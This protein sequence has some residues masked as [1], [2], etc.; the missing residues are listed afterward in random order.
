[1][2]VAEGL[3]DGRDYV[4][5]RRLPKVRLSSLL[6]AT[7]VMVAAA[8]VYVWS[9]INMTKL[10]Y[11]IAE[12]LGVREMLLQEGKKLKLEIATLKS[13]QRIAR[14]ARERLN[15]GPPTQDQVVLIK[16]ETEAPQ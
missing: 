14:I 6:V 1:M 10:E 5:E 13:P 7:V 3:R 16:K 4:E 11:Q 15:M 2:A 9:H 8:L 12:E